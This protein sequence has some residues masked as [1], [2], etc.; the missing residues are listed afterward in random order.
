MVQCVITVSVVGIVVGLKTATC[1][2]RTE[3][4]SK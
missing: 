1:R 2:D 3:R 4:W